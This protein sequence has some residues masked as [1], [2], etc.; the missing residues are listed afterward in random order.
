MELTTAHAQ[1]LWEWLERTG[2]LEC[3][4]NAELADVII[5]TTLVNSANSVPG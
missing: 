1:K 2:Q 3:L 5:G 4:S